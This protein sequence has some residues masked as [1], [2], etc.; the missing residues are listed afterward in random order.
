MMSMCY[1]HDKMYLLGDPTWECFDKIQEA[2]CKN[3]ISAVFAQI[4]DRRGQKDNADLYRAITYY[5]AVE[6]SASGYWRVKRIQGHEVPY[7]A[8]GGTI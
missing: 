1:V 4:Q 2:F 8:T 3:M 7:D 6:A 5:S